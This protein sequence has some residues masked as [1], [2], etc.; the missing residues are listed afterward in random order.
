MMI[1]CTSARETNETNATV[2]STI[3][4]DADR[5]AIYNNADT[6]PIL[7]QPN[8]NNQASEINRKKNIEDWGQTKPHNEPVEVRT[9]ELG[10]PR[11]DTIR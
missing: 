9:M 2:P 3:Q 11:A 10:R 6:R 4:S 1:A 7:R 5:R 8:L